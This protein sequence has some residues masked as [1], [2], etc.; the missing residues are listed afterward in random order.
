M[1]RPKN[2]T[3]RCILV[4]LKHQ[5][6]DALERLAEIERRALGP[7]VEGLILKHFEDKGIKP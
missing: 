3:R 7:Y 5:D 6:L 2:E 1:K 4:S